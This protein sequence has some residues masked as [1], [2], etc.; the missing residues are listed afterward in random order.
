MG[1]GST[2]GA[3]SSAWRHPRHTRLSLNLFTQTRKAGRHAKGVGPGTA[4]RCCSA[5]R[6]AAQP[7]DYMRTTAP[8]ALQSSIQL[9]PQKQANVMQA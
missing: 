7:T 2:C 8:Q 5:Q 9:L 3:S 4:G 1:G 6:A